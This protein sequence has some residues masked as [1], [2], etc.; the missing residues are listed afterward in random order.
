PSR[1]A[2]RV[3]SFAALLLVVSVAATAHADTTKP[4]TE[5]L[6]PDGAIDIAALR[7]SG[8]EGSLD[9]T[10]LNGRIDV[11]SPGI[12]IDPTRTNPPVSAGPP[13]LSFAPLSSTLEGTD[14]A[15]YAV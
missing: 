2:I 4:L 14:G 12:R 6:T 15:V 9:L 13:S 1:R 8:Y 11:S 7:A 3:R 10:G 5:F